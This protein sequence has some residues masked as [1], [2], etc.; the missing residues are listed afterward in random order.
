MTLLSF[1]CSSHVGR[2]FNLF[3]RPAY[4]LMPTYV[5]DANICFTKA[6]AVGLRGQCKFLQS[7]RI[8]RSGRSQ[9]IPVRT[10]TSNT[11]LV[12]H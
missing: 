9:H 2:T 6:A 11:L 12:L 4:V 7:G 5:F 10:S 3:L 1:G 8:E